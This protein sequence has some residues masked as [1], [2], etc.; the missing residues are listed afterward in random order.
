MRIHDRPIQERIEALL[1]LSREHADTFGSPSAWLARERYLAAHPTRIM[2]M[3]CM[4]GRIHIPHATRTPLG[5]ITPFRNL[6]GIFHLGWPY[7]GEMLTDT[8][9]EATRGGHGVLMIITYHFSRGE[10]NR[11]CAGFDCDAEA[12]LSHAREIRAQAEQLFGH[13]H[14]HVYPLV[15]GFET[16]GDALIVHGEGDTR[17]D[18]S[19]L[20]LADASDLERRVTAL[21]PDMPSD[22]RRDLLPLLEGNLQH[23]DSL[24]GVAR[25]LD[26]EHREWVI[27][28]GRGFDFLHLPNTALIVGPYSPDLSQPIGTAAGIIDANMKSSRIPDDGFLL[29]A[30]TPYQE[31]GVDRARAVM[32]SHFLTEFAT[33]VIHREHPKLA[34]R[35]LRRTAVVHWPSRRLELLSDA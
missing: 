1:S 14:R 35:M 20:G 34:K 32:K 5:I 33:R 30:S 23:V 6:G 31:V 4:D 17:L 15:C 21:C 18:M 22:I 16:D 9:Y 28:V 25:E 13:D 11:G 12:A 29:L 27:C 7:L 8:V 24:R 10:K 26:I 2:V 3:K 19:E